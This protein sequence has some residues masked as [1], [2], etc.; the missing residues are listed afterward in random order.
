MLVVFL[1]LHKSVFVLV[2]PLL[3]PHHWQIFRKDIHLIIEDDRRQPDPQ[4]LVIAVSLYFRSNIAGQKYLPH[5]F[6]KHLEINDV[7][8]GQKDRHP[9]AYPHVPDY[10]QEARRE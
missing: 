8:I 7:Q 1:R 3:E 6:D 4:H 5:E 9:L 10:L 2:H